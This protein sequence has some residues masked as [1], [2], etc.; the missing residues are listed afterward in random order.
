[1]IVK[2]VDVVFAAAGVTDSQLPPDVVE[3]LVVNESAAPATDV[4]N[5]TG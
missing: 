1:V 2:G 3:A 5:V 4:V